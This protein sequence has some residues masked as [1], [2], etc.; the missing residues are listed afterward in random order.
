MIR[1][2]RPADSSGVRTIAILLTVIAV[3]YFAQDLFI[4][5]AFAITLA[6]ILTPAVVWLQK[7]PL[8]RP[9]AVVVVMILTLAAAGEASWVIF[10]QLVEVANE[11]PRYQQNIH[12]RLETFRTPG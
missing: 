11:L 8:R 7:L 1:R 5:L 2:V 12:R 9:V 3:L 4:P 6:L 10:R